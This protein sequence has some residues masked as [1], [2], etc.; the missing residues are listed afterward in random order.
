MTTTAAARAS[1]VG[2]AEY[3]AG[4]AGVKSLQ[5]YHREMGD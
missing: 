1:V 3:R 5:T 4:R 2:I